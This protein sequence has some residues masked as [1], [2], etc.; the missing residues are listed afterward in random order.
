MQVATTMPIALI[1]D[2]TYLVT[3]P[4]PDGPG[5]KLTVT[6]PLAATAA[7]RWSG[8]CGAVV[9]TELLFATDAELDAESPLPFPATT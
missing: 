1:A 4:D 9:A 8:G 5:M 2:T 3:E 7:V 6:V